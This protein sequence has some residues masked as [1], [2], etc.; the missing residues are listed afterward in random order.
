MRTWPACWAYFLALSLLAACATQQPIVTTP[1]TYQGAGAGTAVGAGAGALIDKDNRWRGAAFGAALGGV[2]GGSLTE[3]SSRAARE[4]VAANQPV[5]YQSTD[6]WQRVGGHSSDGECQRLPPGPRAC[7][8]GRPVARE[9]IRQVRADRHGHRALSARLAVALLVA[10]AG[11]GGWRGGGSD[12]NAG[13][14]AGHDVFR[15]ARSQVGLAS[16]YGEFHHGLRTAS[17]EI[18][19]MGELTA[20]HRTIPLGT[21][22]RVTNLENGR[23][24]HVRVNDRGPYVGGRVLDL[25]REAARVLDMVERGVVPVRFDLVEH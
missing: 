10:L 8:S 22:L 25:S 23:V 13:R 3:I 19:D 7:L 17:G 21:H 1:R 4:S 12:A 2:L 15:A 24:V 6:G 14:G 16:W 9:Q 11:A 20:A 5:T 18:F